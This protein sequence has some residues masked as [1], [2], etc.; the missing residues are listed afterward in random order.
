MM[1]SSARIGYS[2]AE[3]AEA[4]VV[5]II[6]RNPPTLVMNGNKNDLEIAKGHS[7]RNKVLLMNMSSKFGSD[8]ASNA[9]SEHIALFEA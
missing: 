4:A 8:A 2:E 5:P 1:L 6:S 7:M 9:F 3:A